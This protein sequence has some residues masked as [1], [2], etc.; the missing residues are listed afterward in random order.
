VQDVATVARIVLGAVFLTS[1]VAKMRPSPKLEQV[2]QQFSLGLA[3]PNIA[4]YLARTLPVFELALGLA[5]AAGLWLKIAAALAAVALLL[6]TVSIAINLV[7]GN[8]FR[9]NCFG[10]SSSVIGIG[11]LIRNT[12]L[13]V[14]SLVLVVVVPWMASVIESLRADMRTLTDPSIVA[15]LM[16]G[17]GIYAILLTLDPLSNLFRNA[18]V[19]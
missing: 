17:I 5:I 16:A 12:L 2:V 18:A 19:R 14:G 3:S 7:R 11:S 4:R 10:A 8:R 15:L 13:I 1:A 9:C 6:F